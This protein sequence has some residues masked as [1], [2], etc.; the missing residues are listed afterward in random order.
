MKL[1]SS[2][3]SS[4]EFIKVDTDKAW[5]KV[6]SRIENNEGKVIRIHQPRRNLRIAAGVVLV[7]A[8][9]FS[10]RQLLHKESAQP[11][12][13]ASAEKI[14]ETKLP[15]GSKVFMNKNSEVTFAVKDNVREVKLKGEAY[16]EVVHDEKQ[17]FIV[18]V[19]EILIKDIGTE[20]NVKA[21]PGNNEVEVKV[22]SGEVKFFSRSD[23]GVTLIKGEKASYNKITKQFIKLVADPFDNSASYRSKIFFFKDSKL[24]DVIQ[25]LNDVYLSDIRLGDQRLAECRLTVTFTNEKIETIV[26]ILAETLDLKVQKTGDTF[27]LN[28]ENCTNK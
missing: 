15:D 6:D 16:F 28:G 3:D 25:Q 8:M 20:F 14:T 19:D 1:F 5:Q 11:L 7:L 18:S 26:S 24:K 4:R 2:I 27:V 13:F 17:P 21:L 12:L 22:E 9:A 23:E 10:L